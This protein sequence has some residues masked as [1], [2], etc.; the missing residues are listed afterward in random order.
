[1]IL[2]KKIYCKS[3]KNECRKATTTKSCDTYRFV[4]VHKR[5]CWKSSAQSNRRYLCCIVAIGLGWK[6]VGRFDGMQNLSAKHSRSLVW[7][8]N[9]LWKTFWATI[10]RTDHSVW[11][12]GWVLAYLCERPVKNPSIWKESLTWIVRRI[13][14]LRGRNLEG[15]R[16]GCRH[17]GVGNDGRIWNL[18]E[19]TQCKRGDISQRKRNIHF[20]SRRWTN[21]TSWRKRTSTWIRKHPIWGESRVDFL[22][23]SEGSLPPLHNSFLDVGEAI[24]GYLV[25]VRKLHFPPS[26]WTHSQTLLSERRIIPYSTEVHW[27]I[28]KYSYQFGCQT[29][30]AHRRPLESRWVKRLVW[31]FDRFHSI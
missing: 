14:S 13:R 15:W 16:T 2:R 11:F 9:A 22:G 6:M 19:K 28:Q 25:H 21:Q 27:R 10:W 18:L 20:S 7:W 5:D 17:R 31:I 1:M 24:N 3:T 4:L 29:R 8:E 26:R 23:E 30:E 12:T